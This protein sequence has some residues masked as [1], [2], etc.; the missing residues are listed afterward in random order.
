MDWLGRA[1]SAALSK[2]KP[3]LIAY[4]AGADPYREDQLGGLNLSLEGL[5]ERDDLVFRTARERR[6]P[7]FVTL[8]GGYARKLDDTVT[9]H[10]NMVLAAREV[11]G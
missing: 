8:A 1:M 3:D 5:K 7:V 4:V 11:Y 2:F 6:I 9:I 10:S